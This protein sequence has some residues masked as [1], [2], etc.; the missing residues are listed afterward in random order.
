[1]ILGLIVNPIA[2]IGGRVGLKGSDG[3]EIQQ[4][5]RELGASPVAPE[6][7]HQ[8]LRRLADLARGFQLVT[9][10]A[11]MGEQVARSSGLDHIVIGSIRGE[12]TT[13]DDTVAAAE[14]MKRRNVDLILFAGGDGTARDVCRAIGTT[15]PALGIPAG[16]KIHSAA[17]ATNPSSAGEIAA[18]FLQGNPIT[19]REAEVMDLDEEAYRHGRVSP[20]L[21]GYLKVPF[22]RRRIQG[23]KSPSPVSERGMLKAIALDVIDHMQDGV[24]YIIGPGTTTREIATSLGLEKTLIGVDV[25]CD[26]KRIAPDVNEATLL[27]LL[28]GREAKVV[29]TPVGGQGYVFG[30]GN[31]PISPAVIRK[32]GKGNIQVVSTASKIHALLGRP[33]LVDTGDAELDR[34]LT[35][36]VKVITGY[37][38]RIVY[39]LST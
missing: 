37:G 21:Y 9:W 27:R 26:S 38:E 23:K 15:L 1:V 28:E 3:L 30:R 22:E 13:G 10:P 2:G 32:V 8:A 33:L 19:L 36:Y 24:L 4:R 17:F 14:E 11:E 39:R 29:V 25:V 18:R 7:A 20:R 6:R 5:A 34:D 16:V 35:G 31:Q 12:E